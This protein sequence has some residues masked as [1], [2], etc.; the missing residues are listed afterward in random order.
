MGIHAVYAH[1]QH[2]HAELF[3]GFSFD[4]NCRRFRR[5]DKGE[6]TR[7]EI[8]QHPLPG[9]IRRRTENNNMAGAS[10]WAFA[11]HTDGSLMFDAQIIEYYDNMSIAKGI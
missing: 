4:G 5:S 8:E 3:K 6:I 10:V 9:V 1:H 2:G 11:H 7:I